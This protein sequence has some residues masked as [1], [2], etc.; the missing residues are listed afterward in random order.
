[1]I[2][3]IVLAAGKATRFGS[4]KQLFEIDG[5]PLVQH[6]IDCAS[7]AGLDE[8][9]L[10]IGHDAARVAGAVTLPENARAIVNER[11][12]EGQSTSLAEGL[13]ALDP[14]SEAAVV[15]LG[16]QPG[17]LPGEVR[18]LAARF[19]ETRSPVVRLRYRDAPGPA[20][21]SREIWPEALALSGDT[22]ARELFDRHP[23][24]EVVIERNAPLD[25]D[26][27]SDARAFH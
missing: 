9:V 3:G 19:A 22:G 25:I 7:E 8:I 1:M 13:P 24:E 6:G 27:P 4:T 20:L 21:L 23:V 26:T 18:E 12:A 17:I 10:V 16:D 14:S 5:K 11:Y 15:L 2:S